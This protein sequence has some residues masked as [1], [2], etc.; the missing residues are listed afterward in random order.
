MGSIDSVIDIVLNENKLRTSHM[1]KS[2]MLFCNVYNDVEYFSYIDR[3]QP[4]V[5]MLNAC[6]G[7]NVYFKICIIVVDN[8]SLFGE[9][10]D[11]KSRTIS[12]LDG[13]MV[14][15][16]NIR[17][18]IRSDENSVTIIAKNF[19]ILRELYS[20]LPYVYF[21]KGI[22]KYQPLILHAAAVN[23]VE[24]SACV[25]LGVSGSGKTTTSNLAYKQG[26]EV[27]SDEL[28]CVTLDNSINVFGT[29]ISSTNSALKSNHIDKSSLA[30]FCT[31]EKY[32]SFTVEKKANQKRLALLSSSVENSIYTDDILLSIYKLCKS[33][34]FIHMRFSKKW[35]D[36][37]AIKRMARE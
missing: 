29:M 35:I 18:L 33:T 20:L 15:L 1:Y 4:D 25:F 34:C 32:N 30:V 36:W 23:I 9:L 7:S 11:R 17:V 37:E 10:E 22:F 2:S 14:A 12:Y 13:E 5:I 8:S 21:K 3:T 16:P 24:N 19:F 28:I 31:L 6:C 27:L 26:L